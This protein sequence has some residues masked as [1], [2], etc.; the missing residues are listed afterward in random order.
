MSKQEPDL[1]EAEPEVAKR[2]FL[3]LSRT[4]TVGLALL[5][6]I[7]LGSSSWIAIEAARRNTYELLS[8]VAKLTVE[9]VRDQI[10]LYL[11]TAQEQVT[12]LAKMIEGGEVAPD[13]D[14]RLSDIMLGALAAAP[15]V[16]GIALVR[17]DYTVL[18]AGRSGPDGALQTIVDDWG[19]RV[20]IREAM[21]NAPL[22]ADPRW[23]TVSWID[24]FQSPQI[25]VA[26]MVRHEGRFAGFFFAVVSVQALSAFLSD[27]DRSLEGTTFILQDEEV[28]LAHASLASGFPGLS[29]E[30]ILPRLTD[31]GDDALASIWSPNIDEMTNL[32]AG[33]GVSGHVVLGEDDDTIFIYQ[34]LEVGEI[35]PW[36]VGIYFRG[37]DVDDPFQRLIG[38]ASV[39]AGILV[40]SMILGLLVARSIVRPLRRL[41]SASQKVS[42]LRLEGVK[43]LRG[44]PFRELDISAKAFNSML[45][46]LRLFE[47]YV[48][49][50]LVARLMRN[51][52]TSVVSEERAVTVLF[53]DIVGF[54][55]IGQELEPAALAALLNQHFTL[56]G[57]A[58]EA[59]EGTVDKYIGDSIMAFWGAPLDQPD[60]AQR[61][62][63]AAL[64]IARSL[65]ADNRA[66]RRRGEAPIRL[67]I[68]VNSGPAIVGNIGAPSRVNYTLIGDTVNVAQRLEALGKEIAPED[69][70][71]V[72]VDAQTKALFDCVAEGLALEPLGDFV[73][74]GRGIRSQ[75]YRLREE[76]A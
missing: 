33:S 29:P 2:H 11:Y 19:D 13:D 38:A 72:L 6:I 70:V 4:M 67:R 30:K 68:G 73:L 58:I 51:G 7:S 59:E 57:E 41:A 46:G 63:R 12:F 37:S 36:I 44:S 47:T 75:V 8:S 42:A 56:L 64:A 26:E 16:S 60:H 15:Q 34:E 5:L 66:R 71:V 40:I 52:E 21:V 3:S 20:D 76:G 27:Y 17:S 22:M 43:P 65:Q 25:V 54:T 23:R 31:I 49:R 39:G 48:P 55:Q 1:E 50:N 61:A 45:A 18:Q 74:R 14:A 9:T 24:D 69:D 35:R 32:L 53:T 10:E 62:C 28:V